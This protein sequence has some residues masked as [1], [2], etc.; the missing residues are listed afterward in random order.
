[1]LKKSCVNAPR[2]MLEHLVAIHAWPLG[3]GGNNRLFSCAS[4]HGH[5]GRTWNRFL[6]PRGN[7]H[8][9][10]K[11]MIRPMTLLVFPVLLVAGLLGC[12]SQ[13]IRSTSDAAAGDGPTGNGGSP[14]DAGTVASGGA[15]GGPGTGGTSGF[16]GALGTGGL[17]GSGGAPGTGGLLATGGIVRTGGTFGTGGIVATGGRS[18]SGGLPATG[19][20]AATG[21]LTGSGGRSAT[22]GATGTGGIVAT[23]GTTATGGGTATGGTTGAGGTTGPTDAGPSTC[24]PGPAPTGGTSH[25]NTN[26]T[27]SYGSYQWTLWEGGSGGCLIT[28]DNSDATFS[29]TWNNSGDFLARVGLQWDQTKTYDQLGTIT[30][31]FAETKTG[32]GGGYS[33]IGIYGWTVSPCVEWYIVDD[34]FSAMPIVPGTVS[35]IGT[36]FVDGG[37]Y[38]FY[39]SVMTGTGTSLCSGVSAWSQLWSVRQTARQ[40]GQISVSQHFNEWSKL[41]MTLGK[42]D[43]AVLVVETLGGSGRVDFTTGSVTVQ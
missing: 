1:M 34:S 37:T 3:T 9:H 26:T 31:Q 36:A 28:Y 10:R 32:T 29:A 13:P 40:C 2:V 5:E 33:Y 41:G 24:S 6:P 11:V 30:A 14:G 42:M 16:G 19:G 12:S 39:T 27:G 7:W 22:G 43:E 15:G 23:G 18:G 4:P 21:G 20:A 25:C 38:T 8:Q 17:P 35:K